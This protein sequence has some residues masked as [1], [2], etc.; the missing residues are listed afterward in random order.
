MANCQI[1]EK[2]LKMGNKCNFIL[3]QCKITKKW[4]RGFKLLDKISPLTACH[5]EPAVSS[6]FSSNITSFIPALARWYAILVPTA[7]PPITTVS[8][9]SFRFVFSPPDVDSLYVK[10]QK[11]GSERWKNGKSHFMHYNRPLC[12]VMGIVYNIHLK[13]YIPWF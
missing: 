2:F 13:V 4:W 6:V 11:Q 5:V 10:R 8:A 9:V 12:D 1:D 7:P 3:F